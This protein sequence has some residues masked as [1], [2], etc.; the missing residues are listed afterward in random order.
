MPCL[1]IEKTAK[2]WL[3]EGHLVARNVI[4]CRNGRHGYKASDGISSSLYHSII[5]MN[6]VYSDV[7]QQNCATFI[8]AISLVSVDR[9]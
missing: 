9:F 2:A 6:Y 4:H 8:V 7:F 5:R 1:I 3:T